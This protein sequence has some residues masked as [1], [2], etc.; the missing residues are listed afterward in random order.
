MVLQHPFSAPHSP[1]TLN[2]RGARSTRKGMCFAVSFK[3]A[4]CVRCFLHE[5]SDPLIKHDKRI[6]KTRLCRFLP[7]WYARDSTRI[8]FLVVH[9][10]E[11]DEGRFDLIAV[12]GRNALEVEGRLLVALAIMV[13]WAVAPQ[14]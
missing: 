2:L 9:E 5:T 7:L 10:A 3:T 8:A 6:M 1:H 11:L 14:I 13:I 4:Y 12:V